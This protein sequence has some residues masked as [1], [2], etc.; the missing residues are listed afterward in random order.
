[1]D[2][3][4]IDAAQKIVRVTM[5]P[6]NSTLRENSGPA[7]SDFESLL[8]DSQESQNAFCKI[9]DARNEFHELFTFM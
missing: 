2:A 4:V 5:S 9:T 6:M 8:T 7:A 1:M 3:N